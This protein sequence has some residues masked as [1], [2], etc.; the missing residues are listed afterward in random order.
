MRVGVTVLLVGLVLVSAGAAVAAAPTAITGPV[1]AI[2]TTSA[3]ASGTVNPQRTADELVLRVRHQ[4]ELRQ[5]DCDPERRLGHD[6]RAGVGNADGP[7]ARHDLPLPAGGDERRRHGPRRRRD[8]HH[9]VRAGRPSPARATNVT[10]TSATLN[11]T[12]DPNGRATT[13]YFE[14]GTTTGYGSQTPARSA[15]SGTTSTSVS[16]AGLRPD[17]GTRLPLPARRDERRR[18]EPRSGPDVLDGGRAHGGHGLGLVRHDEIGARSAAPSRRTARRPR[19]TSSTGRPRAYGSK[20]ATR[21]AGAGTRAVNVSAAVGGL[22]M[23]TAYHY[24]LVAANAS[25]TSRGADRTFGTAGPPL[26]RTGPTLDIGPS[27][28]RPTGVVNPRGG[29]R[30]GTSSTARR[31]RYGSRTAAR[32]AGS[33]FGDQNVSVPISRLRTAA[34][35][36]YRL[37]ARNDA[38]TVRGARLTFRTAGV[39]LAARARR[40]VFGRAVMLSGFVPTAPRGRVRDGVRRVRSGLVQGDRDRR[41]GR[42]RAVAV[43]GEAADRHLLHGELERRDEPDDRDRRPAGGLVPPGRRARFHTRVFAARSFA[44]G[45]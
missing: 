11:G 41:D 24:R 7:H 27:T 3:T 29:G 1:S 39:S 34:I 5:E 21:S 43:P 19:G 36:H 42:R 12:V 30:P 31:T 10:V 6:Q 25:G 15:G 2:A 32:S 14:Y 4:H 18:H 13:W 9:L 23:T 37:V 20:T 26:A 22:R 35:Y 33:S 45:S 8:L 40:V 38:G 28:A 16:G 17:T 44:R